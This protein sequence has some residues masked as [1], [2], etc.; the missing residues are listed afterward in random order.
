LEL[1]LRVFVAKGNRLKVVFNFYFEL[2]KTVS[3]EAA[4]ARALFFH[5]IDSTRMLTTQVREN[6][7]LIVT[8]GT[9]GGLFVTQSDFEV[10]VD[11]FFFRS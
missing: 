8:E 6:A 5:S 9:T 2:A 1:S 4:D 7:F 3:T 10:R 11:R